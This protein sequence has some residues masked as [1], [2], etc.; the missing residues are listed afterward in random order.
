MKIPLILLFFAASLMV[1][2]QET[3]DWKEGIIVLRNNQVLNGS[4]F[5]TGFETVLFKTHNRELVSVFRAHDLQQIR[6]YD[7]IINV[8]RRFIIANGIEDFYQDSRLFEVVLDGG[9]SVIR[10]LPI[11][12]ESMMQITYALAYDYFI[13]VDLDI[14][15]LSKFRDRYYPSL[16][17]NCFGLNTFVAAQKLNP[18][19]QADAIRIIK[20]CNTQKASVAFTIL[21]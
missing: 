20:F 12:S 4:L 7:S 14:I 1:S 10:R 15:P 3:D 5:F 13:K 2:A 19:V 21:H 18:N 11:E 8:N 17:K 16:L 9:I 6:F